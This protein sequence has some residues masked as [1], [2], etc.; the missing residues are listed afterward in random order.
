MAAKCHFELMADYNRWMNH[1][2]YRAAGALSPAE[3]LEDRGAFFSSILGTL[4]HLLVG[5]IIWL[6]RFAQPLPEVVALREVRHGR[7]RRG[8]MPCCMTTWRRFS[9]PGKHWMR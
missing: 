6:Q 5:D 2:L 1:N 7:R 4:N 8:W 3:L 9:K